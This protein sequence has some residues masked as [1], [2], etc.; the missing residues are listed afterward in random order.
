[1]STADIGVNDRACLWGAEIQ[2]FLHGH[3]S[4]ETDLGSQTKLYRNHVNGSSQSLSKPRKPCVTHK[5]GVLYTSLRLCRAVLVCHSFSWN[6]KIALITR[7]RM[8]TAEG[9]LFRLQ[10]EKLTSRS[11]N[12]IIYP[13]KPS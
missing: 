2:H 9:I 12:K 7:I 4:V 1:V 6:Q 8:Y 5:P 11:S 13:I 10:Q 3:C